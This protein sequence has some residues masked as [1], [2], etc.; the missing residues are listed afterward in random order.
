VA[1]EPIGPKLAEG[2]DSEIFEHGAGRV[3]RVNRVARDLTGEAR[4]IQHVRSQG[5]PAPEVFDAGDGWL[6][7]ER[8]DGADLL[9][10]IS[11][12]PAGI[13][14]AA[15][16]LADLHAQLGAI[17]AP[18]WMAAAPGPAGDRVVH[19]DLHPLNVMLTRDGPVVIDWGN[20]RRGVPA[21]DVADTWSLLKAG[22]IPGRGLERLL[23]E[24]GRGLLL[25]SFL[26]RVDRAAAA[27]VIPAVVEWRVADRNMS[28]KEKERLRA[29]ATAVS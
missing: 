19:L 17:E 9:D 15:A 12:T 11:K 16:M 28:P 6:V 7:M 29:L 20:A 13:R 18:E 25:R 27:R 4:V 23:S 5:Y 8:I 24:L 10:A 2:R 3:L 14:R 26:R 1:I 21:V 22:Q